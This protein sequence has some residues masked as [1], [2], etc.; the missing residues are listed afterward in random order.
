VGLQAVAATNREA[1]V[2]RL[3]AALESARPWANN[4]PELRV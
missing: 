1:D 2:L 3:G 4:H